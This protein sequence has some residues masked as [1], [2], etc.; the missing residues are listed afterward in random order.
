MP[1]QIYQVDNR[2]ELKIDMCMYFQFQT[3][4]MDYSCT[5]SP[6]KTNCFNFSLCWYLL[7]FLVIVISNS[8]L[9]CKGHSCCPFTTYIHV[10][11]QTLVLI[12]YTNE[13]N[14]HVPEVQLCS[15]P[16]VAESSA[17]QNFSLQSQA[18]HMMWIGYFVDWLIH[19]F[20]VCLGKGNCASFHL[21]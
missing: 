16:L 17:S 3:E 14:K 19:G 11:R 15:S 5:F 12:F 6:K 8:M 9:R 2:Y 4:H 10:Y 1:C 20:V 13:V 21:K 18:K 7:C